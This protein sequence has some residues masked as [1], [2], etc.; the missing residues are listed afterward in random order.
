MKSILILNGQ[1]VNEG[2]VIPQDIFIRNGRFEK[3]DGDLASQPADITLDADGKYLLPGL[4]DDQVHFRQPGL[5]HKGN[6]FSESRAAVA[7]GV[8]S[9]MDMPNTSP[10]TLSRDRL[11][12]K[13][14]I[15]ARTSLANYGFYLGAAN[16]NIEEI[17]TLDPR[18]ACGIKVF[19][20][21]SSGN[22]LVDDPRTLE[23]IFA[24]APT[25]VAT[26]C[27]DTPT[28]LANETQARKRW[29]EDVP[30]DR[31]PSIR[32]SEACFKSSLFAVELARTHGT[33]LHVLHL[34]TAREMTLFSDGDI[35]KKRIT[36]E[37]CVHHLFF[38][39]RDYRELGA[40]IKCNPAIKGKTD[41]R[42]LIDAVK[43]GRIDIIATDHA[44]HTFA[45]KQRS[46]FQSPSGLPLVQHSLLILLGFVRDGVFDL[47]LIVEKTSHAPAR[48]FQIEKRGYIRE[49][50]WADLV[51]VDLTGATRV[52][53]KNTL[54]RCGW[55]PFEGHTFPAVIDTTIVSGHLAY[56]NSRPDDARLGHRLT[57]RRW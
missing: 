15:A 42:G 43:G 9:F 54:Y 30:M 27:E 39:D 10:P 17:K 24:H 35:E 41:R 25:L 16:D 34:S 11:E 4:I 57:H 55:S 21:A 33:R 53:K 40:R 44:P 26:H 36:A 1:V 18:R 8:T 28:I 19:M 20:G 48:L 13:Y 38:S 22:L 47:P 12:E 37:V 45:E 23:D 14:R 32:S 49:G 51:I 52:D 6:I 56:H 2:T 7:G 46:Y 5:T 31:H 50:Y 3:L 29:G